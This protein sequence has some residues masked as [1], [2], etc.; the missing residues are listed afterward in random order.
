MLL[1]AEKE[2]RK[3]RMVDVELFTEISVASETWH[4]WKIALEVA[5]EKFVA[6]GS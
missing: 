3:L 2:C 5:E 1:H 4:V 6:R